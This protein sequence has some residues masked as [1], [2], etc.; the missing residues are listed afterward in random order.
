MA[1]DE[2]LRDTRVNFEINRK[3]LPK[4][5][6][7]TLDTYFELHDYFFN[8]NKALQDECT[9]LLDQL[10]R[11][12]Y[13]PQ[14]GE[15]H[16]V[17]SNWI[18]ETNQADCFGFACQ[19]RGLVKQMEDGI[20]IAA[21]YPKLEE[22]RAFYL[23][24]KPSTLEDN[25]RNRFLF[26]DDEAWEKEKEKE[27]REMLRYFMWCEQRKKE[28]YDII[29]PPMFRLYPALQ[30]LEG[31]FWLLYAVDLRDLYE[32]WLTVMEEA[33]SVVEFEMDPEFINK[34]YAEYREEYRKRSPVY[35]K[36]S[37]EKR[38]AMINSVKLP[39]EF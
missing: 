1:D 12:H 35:S 28:F 30:N 10:A 37:Q 21:T 33:Q 16:P 14:A 15:L 6:T 4:D 2:K 11:K 22:W 31:D 3:H 34:P 29:Q 24:E 39:D 19:M 26:P 32:E 5:F 23:H 25:L 38:E 17:I 27:N 7:E 9:P 36:K 13:F 8:V 20:D 18:T